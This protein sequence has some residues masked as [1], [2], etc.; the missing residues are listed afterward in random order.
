MIW[1]K[2]SIVSIHVCSFIQYSAMHDG[3]ISFKDGCYCTGPLAVSLSLER[4]RKN[5]D[6]KINS[7]EKL[8]VYILFC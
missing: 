6:D 2:L 7:V 3:F 8:I 1:E 4:E 5:V